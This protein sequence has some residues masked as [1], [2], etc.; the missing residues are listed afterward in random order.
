MSS[1]ATLPLRSITDS[2]TLADPRSRYSSG[3][4]YGAS[5]LVRSEDSMRRGD[6]TTASIEDRSD[7]RLHEDSMA[8]RRGFKNGWDK[9]S[10][11]MKKEG[12]TR[13]CA[14]CS[15]QLARYPAVL[16]RARSGMSGTSDGIK[17]D[18]KGKTYRNI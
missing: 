8:E 17:T 9:G 18:A 3:S 2:E 6:S 14:N 7:A 10:D 15:V 16:S 1:F 4:S 11:K 5:A 12:W 13:G